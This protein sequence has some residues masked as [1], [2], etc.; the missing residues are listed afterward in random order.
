MFGLCN[1]E[2]KSFFDKIIGVPG[3][4]IHSYRIFNIA[5]MDVI[6]VLIG[7]ILLA[8]LLKWNYIR[9]IIGMFVIGIV[10]HRL[11]CVK[12]VLDKWLFPY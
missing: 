9:T 6:V 8:K 10:I 4:G 7:S 12:T 11:F 2:L 5:Y 3:V 1:R